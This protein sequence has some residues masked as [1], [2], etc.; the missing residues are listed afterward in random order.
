MKWGELTEAGRKR[1]E[2]IEIYDVLKYLTN[3]ISSIQ[4]NDENP[5]DNVIVLTKN[6]HYIDESS[7]YEF[8]K[9]LERWENGDVID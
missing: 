7:R 4:F 1:I 3:Q 8:E 5:G 2:Y 6:P 9:Q